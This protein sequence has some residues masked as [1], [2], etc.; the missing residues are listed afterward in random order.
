MHAILLAGPRSAGLVERVKF[1]DPS[2]QVCL[3]DELR[4]AQEALKAS[5]ER[6][7]FIVG[8]AALRH[9]RRNVEFARQLAAALRIEVKAKA[10]QN[11]IRDLLGDNNPAT[12]AP[13]GG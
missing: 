13:H 8:H 10:D 6:R 4:Q 11:A 3:Q 9:I 12:W 1:H 2:R 5:E 7:A